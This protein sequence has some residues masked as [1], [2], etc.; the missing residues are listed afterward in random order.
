[1]KK[2]LSVV[3]IATFA[4]TTMSAQTTSKNV[5]NTVDN[6]V[7]KVSGQAT[8]IVDKTSNGI[9]T[10]YGD[11]KDAIGIVYGDLKSLAP[12]V[13]SALTEVAKGLKVG[14]ES[15]WKIL[16]K[17]QLVWSF[18]YLIG[19]I[20]TIL[21][22]VNFYYRFNKGQENAKTNQGDWKEADGVLVI[23]LF[24]ISVA[25]S[26]LSIMNI[27]AMMTGFINPEFGAIRN[28][29]EIASKLK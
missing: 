7:N 6:T 25:L 22:W 16:V 9:G 11:S 23:V 12:K 27:E 5:T 3:L 21:S 28:I 10:V 20:V 29:V 4:F 19:I 8:N 13:E 24:I 2:L 17:Q 1:M 14:A 15:V 26:I 18:C